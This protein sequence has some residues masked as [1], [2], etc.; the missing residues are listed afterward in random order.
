M[1]QVREVADI[2]NQVVDATTAKTFVAPAGARG[3]F[4]SCKTADIW[5]WPDGSHTAAASDGLLIPAGQPPVYLPFAQ[6]ISAFGSGASCP[7][8]V[9]WVK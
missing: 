5:V 6:D 1:S 7:T 3:C 9:C 2:D 8:S 4:I